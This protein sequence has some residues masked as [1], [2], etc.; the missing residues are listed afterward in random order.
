MSVTILFL[1]VFEAES[2]EPE[3]KRIET[4][5]IYQCVILVAELLFFLFRSGKPTSVSYDA[6]ESV[7]DRFER[8]SRLDIFNSLVSLAIYVI[9]ITWLVYGNY[10]YFTLPPNMP[11]IVVD[12][13]ASTDGSTV[14]TKPAIDYEDINSEKWLYVTLMTVLTIG[15]VHL[16]IFI[17]LVVIFFVYALGN[18]VL[19]SEDAQSQVGHL[20]PVKLWL[21]I[22]EG[23]FSLLDDLD[24]EDNYPQQQAR[25]DRQE[26]ARRLA[27]EKLENKPFETVRQ[28]TIDQIREGNVKGNLNS[29]RSPSNASCTPRNG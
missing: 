10:I 25:E 17:A 12:P 18:C 16:M 7:S 9:Q 8:M 24:E 22:D 14:G 11:S 28:D 3:F 19:S 26:A 1:V 4:W 15:Y 20:S 23:I 29:F 27:L 21:F 6:Y 13:A 2:D 5:L